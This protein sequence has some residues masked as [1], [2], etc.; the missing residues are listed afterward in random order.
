MLKYFIIIG[1]KSLNIPNG[2][3]R[4]VNTM[5]KANKTNILKIITIIICINIEF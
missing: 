3:Q 5:A 2:D 1:N 4:T